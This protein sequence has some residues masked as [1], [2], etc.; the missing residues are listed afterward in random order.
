M[1]AASSGAESTHSRAA[2]SADSGGPERR[3]VAGERPPILAAVG[4]IG[5]KKRWR[6]PTLRAP[7]RSRSSR[8]DAIDCGGSPVAAGSSLRVMA[9]HEPLLETRAAPARA[10]TAGPLAADCHR[11]VGRRDDAAAWWTQPQAGGLAQRR[12]SSSSSSVS[13]LVR[14]VRRGQPVSQLSN[15]RPAPHLLHR[16]R[17]SHSSAAGIAGNAPAPRLTV[18][19]DGRV[20]RW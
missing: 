8:V 10:R 5:R 9:F 17:P 12:I 18:H 16:H 19:A 1:R 15:G 7:S 20:R 2:C 4:A 13:I 14:P 3:G 6:Q 11:T